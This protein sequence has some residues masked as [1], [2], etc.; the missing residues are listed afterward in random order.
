M[1][2]I[3]IINNA[4][5]LV[6]IIINIILIRIIIIM[7]HIRRTLG[8]FEIILDRFRVSTGFDGNS[9]HTSVSNGF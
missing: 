3:I 9:I 8:H 7:W 1:A 5:I 2:T 6:I 4:I